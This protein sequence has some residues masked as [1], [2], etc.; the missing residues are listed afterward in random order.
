M[1]RSGAVSGPAL[2]EAEISRRE[3]PRRLS[4][5]LVLLADHLGVRTDPPAN[6]SAPATFLL[7][8]TYRMI[9]ESVGS[10]GTFVLI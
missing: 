10:G 6:V 5:C 8:I 7:S 1:R 3:D 4:I 2:E 9:P